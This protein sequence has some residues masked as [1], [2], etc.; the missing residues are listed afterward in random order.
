[1]Y[2][3]VFRVDQ[4]RPDNITGDSSQR[5]LIF[6]SFSSHKTTR[7][8]SST[9][10]ALS[11]PPPIGMLAVWSLNRSYLGRH[12][13]TLWRFH[14]C[15]VPAMSRRHCLT[16]ASC[17]SLS[18]NLSVSSFTVTPSPVCRVVLCV[19]QLGL[20]TPGSL[21]LGIFTGCGSPSAA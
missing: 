16:P 7:S 2:V 10:G 1:M 19:Y 17:S 21:I 18:G 20:C 12:I 15:S 4:W 14:G 5:K 3:H 9:G 13:V 11:N 8:S 6:R